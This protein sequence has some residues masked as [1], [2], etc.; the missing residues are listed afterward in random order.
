MDSEYFANR[1]YR[2]SLV[3]AIA[4]SLMVVI[5]ASLLA[6]GRLNVRGA[7]LLEEPREIT[8]IALLEPKLT[9]GTTIDF[10]DFLR[11]ES[12]VTSEEK[13][14]YSYHVKTSDESDYLLQL[15]YDSE[16]KQWGIH[17]IERLHASAAATPL[18]P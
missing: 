9:D 14:V 15:R 10:V 16:K 12:P 5:L 11:K 1:G 18:L 4:L 3:L 17:H 7:L 2:L 13:A 6:R 8:V